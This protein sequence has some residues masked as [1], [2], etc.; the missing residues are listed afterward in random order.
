MLLTQPERRCELVHSAL[1]SPQLGYKKSS[2]S[3]PIAT[4][5]CSG[6]TGV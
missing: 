5:E 2:L 4:R 3:K 6:L 1:E